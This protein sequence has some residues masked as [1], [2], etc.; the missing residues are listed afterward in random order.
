MS[1]RECR[2]LGDVREFLRM[3]ISR[4]GQKI[5][6]HQLPYLNKVLECCGMTNCKP[7]HTPLPEGYNPVA[8]TE[9]VNAERRSQYQM[10][11]GS[12]SLLYLML[13]SRP[14]IAFAVI[15]LAQ[16]SAN[17]SKRTPG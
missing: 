13:G 10:V 8:N 17:L 16:H 12:L 14:D 4:Q 3:H 7:A 6:I 1:K 9:S 2:D 5:I 15:K 11:I